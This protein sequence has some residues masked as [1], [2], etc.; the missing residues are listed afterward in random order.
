MVDR[1]PGKGYRIFSDSWYAL[2]DLV[3]DISEKNFTIITSLRSNT[4]DLPNKESIDNSSKKY[5][6]NIKNHFIIHE[7]K[8]KKQF[9]LLQMKIYLLK[10]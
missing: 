2:V 10:K 1:L 9:I 3:K 7:F 5:V 6:N 4:S 8:D